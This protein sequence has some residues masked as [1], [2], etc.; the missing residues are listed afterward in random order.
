MSYIEIL[1]VDLRKF[2]LSFLSKWDLL[3]FTQIL[4]K[5]K[6]ASILNEKLWQQKLS[7]DFS[8]PVGP[9]GQR[10]PDGMS[11]FRGPTGAMGYWGPIG[12]TG[13][14]GSTSSG[15]INNG[16]LGAVSHNVPNDYYKFPEWLNNENKDAYNVCKNIDSISFSSE[17]KY[18]ISTYYGYVCME[19]DSYFMD[20]I[21]N[22]NRKPL[23][24]YLKEKF[25][26]IYFSHKS[27]VIK[28][29]S[30]NKFYGVSVIEYFISLYPQYV[31]F[32]LLSL[33]NKLKFTPGVLNFVESLYIKYSSVLGSINMDE[34][35][36][37]NGLNEENLCYWLYYKLENFK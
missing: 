14:V 19:P 27:Y 20:L 24:E 36:M 5:F 34:Y 29:M 16:L 17:D 8:A 12:A 25:F 33:P 18:F 35:I 15:H 30:T 23:D 3:H 1:P 4:H 13:A 28:F 26:R 6:L 10:G 37:F 32:V 7:Q 11:G 31:R 2:L 9:M 22:L 21:L